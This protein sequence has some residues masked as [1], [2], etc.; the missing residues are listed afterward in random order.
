M[1]RPVKVTVVKRGLDQ[2]LIGRLV[3]K[4]T[5]IERCSAFEDGQEFLFVDWPSKPT[6]F[7]DMAWQA[8]YAGLMLCWFD[9][10]L[11]S[12]TIPNK[13]QACCPDGLR[14]VVFLIEPIESDPT[15]VRPA[16]EEEER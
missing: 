3:P 11:G 13:W 4:E 7:C 10:D 2:D 8:I 14:P 6:G 9:A 15:A 16:E 12:V 5:P 1:T